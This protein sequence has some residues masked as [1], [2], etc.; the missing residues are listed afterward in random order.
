MT[1][2]ARLSRARQAVLMPFWLAQVF[3]QEKFFAR[4]PVIGNPWLNEHGLHTARLKLAHRLAEARRR[5]LAPLIPAEDRQ[6]FARD[7]FV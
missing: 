5:R 3:S 4:N 6:S 1:A 7:G 2:P